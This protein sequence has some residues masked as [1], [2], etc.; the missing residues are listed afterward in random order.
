MVEF[1]CYNKKRKFR[2]IDVSNYKYVVGNKDWFIGIRKDKKIEKS[3]FVNCNKVSAKPDQE[4][5]ASF[6]QSIS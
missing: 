4:N 6:D 1:F 3:G 5:D 2:E